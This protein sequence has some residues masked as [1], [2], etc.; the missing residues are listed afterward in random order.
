MEKFLFIAIVSHVWL[1]AWA[2]EENM[3][4]KLFCLISKFAAIKD[5]NDS[6]TLVAT[7]AFE[8]LETV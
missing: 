3:S 6:Q 1:W 2:P 4:V 7:K 8:T 5:A